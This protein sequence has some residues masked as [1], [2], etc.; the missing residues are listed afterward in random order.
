[1]TLKLP[2]KDVFPFLFQC[3]VPSYVEK[4]SQ[5]PRT[6]S[7]GRL[8]TEPKFRRGLTKPWSTLISIWHFQEY[9]PYFPR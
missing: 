6:D 5:M 1:M 4:L 3:D 9:K 8:F 7:M 2:I